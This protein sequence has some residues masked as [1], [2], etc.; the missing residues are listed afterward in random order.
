MSAFPKKCISSSWSRNTEA[1]LSG[2]DLSMQF[3]T[4]GNNYASQKTMSDL[5]NNFEDLI[6][7]YHLKL[8]SEKFSYI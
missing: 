8:K 3:E 2:L 4:D 6:S 7:S 1:C 5:G